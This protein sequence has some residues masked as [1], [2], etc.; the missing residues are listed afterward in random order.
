MLPKNKVKLLWMLSS[1]KER[2]FKKEG[3]YLTTNKNVY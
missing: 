1:E 2:T 3:N